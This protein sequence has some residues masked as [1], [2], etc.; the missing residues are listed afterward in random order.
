MPPTHQPN[1]HSMGKVMVEDEQRGTS[2]IVSMPPLPGPGVRKG[3]ERREK[4]GGGGQ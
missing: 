4:G 2:A 1:A 3:E